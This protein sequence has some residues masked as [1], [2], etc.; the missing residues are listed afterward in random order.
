M[1]HMR[2]GSGAP[3]YLSAVLEYL[4][5][6]VLELAANSA[7]DNRKKRIRPRDVRLAVGHDTELSKLCQDVTFSEGG[8]MVHINVELYHLK[9]QRLIKLVVQGRV[10][11]L[12]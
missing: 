10:V 5:A 8:N 9:S 1:P 4:S 2:L 12:R 3:V 11:L 6:E 7:R